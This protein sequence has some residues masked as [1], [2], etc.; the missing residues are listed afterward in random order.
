MQQDKT[1][2]ENVELRGEMN[3]QTIAEAHQQLCQAFASGKNVVADI[4]NATNPDLSFIQLLVSAQ[5]TA[6]NN[7]I[8]FSLLVPVAGDIEKIIRRGGFDTPPLNKLW[9]LQQGEENA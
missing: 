9:Q 4:S 1:A 3:I 7:G 8:S 6:R 2:A 5:N